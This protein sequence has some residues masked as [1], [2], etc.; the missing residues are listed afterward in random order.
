MFISLLFKFLRK[1]LY[2]EHSSNEIICKF[3]GKTIAKRHATILER[4]NFHLS[5]LSRPFPIRFHT[6]PFHYSLLLRPSL[7]ALSLSLSLV[8]PQLLRSFPFTLLS[9]HEARLL[10]A[11]TQYRSRECTLNFGGPGTYSTMFYDGVIS[12]RGI[13]KFSLDRVISGFRLESLVYFITISL[14]LWMI[15]R[16]L[17]TYDL[18]SREN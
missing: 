18:F 3:V 17:I 8:S 11:R 15:V 12:E 7:S 9:P 14:F 4:L 13:R 10:H 16:K 5:S 2:F 6:P 1:F